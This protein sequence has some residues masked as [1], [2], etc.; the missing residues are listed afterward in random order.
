MPHKAAQCEDRI[1]AEQT[2]PRGRD[3]EGFDLGRLVRWM[4]RVARRIGLAGVKNIIEAVWIL[5]P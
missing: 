3:I 1:G 5:E 4:K 2:R